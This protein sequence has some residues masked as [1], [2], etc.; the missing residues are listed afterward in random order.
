MCSVCEQVWGVYVC[1]CG[2]VCRRACAQC[3][4]ICAQVVRGRLGLTVWCAQTILA[5]VTLSTVV[6][7]AGGRSSCGIERWQ[8]FCQGRGLGRWESLPFTVQT[9]QNASSACGNSKPP[10]QVCKGHCPPEAT[11]LVTS[12]VLMSPLFLRP[13]N[14]CI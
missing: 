6:L 5:L 10:D 4:G 8:W 14:K 9:C 12:E 11:P 1:G 3:G 2:S 13:F 7:L